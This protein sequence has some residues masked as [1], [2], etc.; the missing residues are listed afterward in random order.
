MYVWIFN[1]VHIYFFYNPN[2]IGFLERVE[3]R[4]S[5]TALPNVSLHR[6]TH[7]VYTRDDTTLWYSRMLR[8]LIQLNVV[9]HGQ[10]DM[11]GVIRF[12]FASLQARAAHIFRVISSLWQQP[13]YS[14]FHVLRYYLD[15]WKVLNTLSQ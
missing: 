8:E 15:T 13:H 6:P 9:S 2:H 14:H 11:P 3:P 4:G 12:L 5:P 7:I 1:I 10:V